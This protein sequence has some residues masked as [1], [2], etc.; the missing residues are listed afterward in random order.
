MASQYGEVNIK[1]INNQLTNNKEGRMSFLSTL[2]SMGG[3]VFEGYAIHDILKASGKKITTQAEG[4]VA[5]IAT[6]I[7]LAGDIRLITENSEVD[8]T[9][10]LGLRRG[11]QYRSTE[12]CRQPQERRGQAGSFLYA[13]KTGAT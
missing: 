4:L 9:Q 7:Y 8:G 5:S 3:D 2:N 6:V 1:D 11:R 13:N 12:I 10:P